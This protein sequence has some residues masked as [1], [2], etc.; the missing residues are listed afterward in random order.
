MV[1]ERSQSP[2]VVVSVFVQIPHHPYFVVG[3]VRLRYFEEEE[4]PLTRT[5]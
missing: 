3:S 1:N 2:G 4:E 5:Y